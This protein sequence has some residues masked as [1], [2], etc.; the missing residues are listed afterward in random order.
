MVNLYKIYRKGL[1]TFPLHKIKYIRFFNLITII[2]MSE[3]DPQSM[4]ERRRVKFP[5]VSWVGR[6]PERLLAFGL[7]SG[8]IRPGSGTWGTVCAWLI[9]L[10]VASFV[11]DWAM[12]VFLVLAFV[13]G[14]WICQRVG[15]ALQV[16]D[17]VGIVWDE[18]VSFW[19]ILWLVPQTW[20]AQIL[21]FAL[22]RVFDTV[23]PQPIKYLDARVTGGVG[24]MLDD[25]LAAVYTLI[26]MFIVVRTGVL[27]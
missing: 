19:L 4:R 23:K 3:P 12:G 16:S 15:D 2:T 6:S 26:I 7:G 20:T 5:S 8:L 13:Y 14:C 9:W 11:P 17:H 22:F 10:G 21:A 25:L 27:Q 18:M 24:V 1:I